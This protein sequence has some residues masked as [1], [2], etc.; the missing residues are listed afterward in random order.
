[1]QTALRCDYHRRATCWGQSY[2]SGGDIE[3]DYK[4]FHEE[5]TAF[6]REQELNPLPAFTGIQAKLCRPDLLVE[7]EAIARPF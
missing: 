7:I 1:M 2:Q 4:E 6:C 3:R 5:R